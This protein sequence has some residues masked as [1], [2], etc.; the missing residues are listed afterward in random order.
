VVGVQ[1]KYGNLIVCPL[2]SK[3]EKGS[4]ILSALVQDDIVSDASGSLAL[5]VY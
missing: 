2:Y 5:A 4:K 3:V 1:H